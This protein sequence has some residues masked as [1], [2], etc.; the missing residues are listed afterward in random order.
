MVLAWSKFETELLKRCELTQDLSAERNFFLI[1]GTDP[2]HLSTH[3]SGP[4]NDVFEEHRDASPGVLHLVGNN[5]ET[6]APRAILEI[7][8]YAGWYSELGRLGFF[9]GIGPNDRDIILNHFQ[10]LCRFPG[11][12]NSHFFWHWST[13]RFYLA[14]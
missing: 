11:L 12:E 3:L 8:Q 7:E 1:G 2:L 4:V 14:L 9:L 6:G 10:L 13:H 5:T